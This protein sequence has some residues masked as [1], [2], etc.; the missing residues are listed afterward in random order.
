M[1]IHCIV[2]YMNNSTKK[3]ILPCQSSA[4]GHG[5]W[6]RTPCPD[7]A[8]WQTPRSL[9]TSVWTGWRRPHAPGCWADASS[10]PPHHTEPAHLYYC[11]HPPSPPADSHTHKYNAHGKN[12]KDRETEKE[13]MRTKKFGAENEQSNVLLHVILSDCYHRLLKE[14]RGYG[15]GSEGHLFWFMDQSELKHAV[16]FWHVTASTLQMPWMGQNNTEWKRS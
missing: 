2:L 7:L 13:V 11:W 9:Q 6:T 12:D 3:Q 14:Q 15:K 4:S 1:L 16:L 10:V 8:G 5:C